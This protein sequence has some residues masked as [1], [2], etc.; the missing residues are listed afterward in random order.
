MEQRLQE[1]KE[2]ITSFVREND[3]KKFDV[4][5]SRGITIPTNVEIEIRV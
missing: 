3:I 5:I 4:C 1:L 2:K